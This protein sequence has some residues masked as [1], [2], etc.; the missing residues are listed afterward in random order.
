LRGSEGVP[1]VAGTDVGKDG[2]R[3][4]VRQRR[5]ALD[6]VS[7]VGCTQQP[8]SN[9]RVQPML[10]PPTAFYS[11]RAPLGRRET[12]WIRLKSVIFRF[13]ALGRL[14]TSQMIR[15]TQIMATIQKTE[16]IDYVHW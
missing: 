2:S 15:V 16:F 13:S 4:P 11:S 3:L 10:P 6:F 14:L 8:N 1:A 7:G 5:E 12:L 9:Q